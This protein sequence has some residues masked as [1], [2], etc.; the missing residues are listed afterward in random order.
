M[1]V[2]KRLRV[3]MMV[4]LALMVPVSAYA[5]GVIED[6]TPIAE[7]LTN[8]LRFLLSLAGILAIL[9]LAVSGVLYMVAGG[10]EQ[11]AATAKN[12]MLFSVVGIVVILLSLVIVTRL[13]AFF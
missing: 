5:A 4:P 10:D 7:V 9:S 1:P 12:M 6:A 11:R 13:A 8:I 3:V 2:M